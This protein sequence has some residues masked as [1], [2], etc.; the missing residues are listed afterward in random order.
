MK[1]RLESGEIVVIEVQSYRETAYLPRIL[2]GTTQ[3]INDHIHQGDGFEKVVK[4]IS[5]SLLFDQRGP[6]DDYMYYGRTLIEGVH[7]GKLFDLTPHQRDILQ[8][9]SAAEIFPRYYFI[10]VDQFD[11]VA[12]T[13]LDE[14]IHFL[15][16]HTLPP[17]FSAPGLAEAYELFDVDTIAEKT[18]LEVDDVRRL[19][20]E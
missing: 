13:K 9:R 15:K 18:G 4:V 10:Y 19:R 2:L 20:T 11:T 6:T 14:W 12:T 16:Y 1:V 17:N 5:L 8:A 7:D 3:V